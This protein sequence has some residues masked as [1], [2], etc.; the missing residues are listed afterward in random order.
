MVPSKIIFYLLQDGC[1]WTLWVLVGSGMGGCGPKSAERLRRL[2]PRQV[3]PGVLR[4]LVEL[5]LEEAGTSFTT[6]G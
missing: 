4:E 2:Q 3:E 5:H 6:H 1:T